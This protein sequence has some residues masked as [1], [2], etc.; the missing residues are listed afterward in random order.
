MKHVVSVERS[1][2]GCW[3]PQVVQMRKDDE[4]VIVSGSCWGDG[5]RLT[6]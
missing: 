6:V 4:S 3:V 2:V 1:A 5:M